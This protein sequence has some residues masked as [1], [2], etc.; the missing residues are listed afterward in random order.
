MVCRLFKHIKIDLIDNVEHHWVFKCVIN[1][2]LLTIIGF[3]HIRIDFIENVEHQWTFG[4][5][6][7]ITKSFNI[8]EYTNTE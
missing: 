1:F 3:K 7:E 6:G 2:A 8:H 5:V 4:C